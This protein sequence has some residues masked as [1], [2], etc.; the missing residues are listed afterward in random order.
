M[1]LLTVRGGGF[2]GV[3]NRFIV[4]VWMSTLGVLSACVTFIAVNPFLYVHPLERFTAMLLVRRREIFK[5]PPQVPMDFS[6]AWTAFQEMFD[7]ELLGQYYHLAAILFFLGMV[8]NIGVVV[9][10]LRN[11]STNSACVVMI[12][13]FIFL[14]VPSFAFGYRFRRYYL[15]AAI[16][17][18]YFIAVGLGFVWVHTYNS[19]MRLW[20]GRGKFSATNVTGD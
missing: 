13:A 7:G 11:R 12:L 8:L 1:Y 5:V 9:Q 19:L 2:R 3:T 16:F 6:R 4:P 17:G 18:Y 10:W 15:F 14:A 20:L